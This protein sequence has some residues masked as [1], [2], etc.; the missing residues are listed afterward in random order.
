MVEREAQRSDPVLALDPV[1]VHRLWRPVERPGVIDPGPAR[2]MLARH[3]R[4]VAGLPLAELVSR[5]TGSVL[6]PAV[7]IVYALPVQSPSPPASPSVHRST[8]TLVVQHEITLPPTAAPPAAAAPS[9][10]VA[11]SPAASS[12]SSGGAGPVPERP[13]P[14][15]PREPHPPAPALRMPAA[16]PLAVD[17]LGAGPRGAG[18]REPRPSRWGTSAAPDLPPPDAPAGR[19][20]TP[21]RP[22]PPVSN[23]M[24]LPPLEPRMPDARP[25]EAGSPS[26]RSADPGPPRTGVPAAMGAPR[27]VLAGAGGVSRPAGAADGGAPLVRAAPPAPW[28]SWAPPVAA[29]VPRESA[30]LPRAVAAT[31]TPTR[32]R[33]GEPLLLVDPTPTASRPAGDR[34][35]ATG[36]WAPGVDHVPA[37]I[38]APVGGHPPGT[39]Q[40]AAARRGADRAAQAQT[41]RWATGPVD[42]EH[43]V[44]AVHRRFV[45]RLAIETER[46]GV[47]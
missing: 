33:L 12:S 9:A 3:Q 38:H 8:S 1:L 41:G 46:R 19:A 27:V 30:Q 13:L 37:V 11:L 7:P 21:T 16:G 35:A 4:M 22:A 2:A 17:S 6:D 44:E 18:P 24:D 40:G 29:G 31:V 23:R 26:A 28:P 42:V 32:S 5:H 43:I 36:Q 25:S 39:G 34:S 47:R 15:G 10:A 20:A 14:T 45:R